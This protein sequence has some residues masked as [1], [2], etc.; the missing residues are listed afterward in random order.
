MGL[1]DSIA[2]LAKSRRA[3]TLIA[4]ITTFAGVALLLDRPK[5]SVLEW[6]GIPFIIVG[7]AAFAAAAWPTGPVPGQSAPNLANRPL[8]WLTW[9][10]RLRKL[11]P[12][13]GVGIVVA[14]AAYQPLR[15]VGP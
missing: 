2:A 4:L 6:L 1:R 8:R 14:R 3:T 13:F 7:G 12:A 9:D 11:F 5:G 10:R 15:S